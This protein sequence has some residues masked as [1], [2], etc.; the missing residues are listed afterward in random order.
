LSGEA[1]KLAALYE[2]GRMPGR[3]VVGIKAVLSAMG[4]CHDAV[5]SSFERFGTGTSVAIVETSSPPA[6]RPEPAVEFA[7]GVWTREPGVCSGW[8]ATPS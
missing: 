8:H 4:I 5:A 2:V 7:A 6:S 3:I 1:R